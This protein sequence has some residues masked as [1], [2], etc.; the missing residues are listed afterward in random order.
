MGMMERKAAATF[1]TETLP[2]LK[3]QIQEAC[4]FELNIEVNLDELASQ[5]K[6]DEFNEGW[7]KIYFQPLNKAMQEICAD[8]FGK[9]A[10]KEG[11]KKVVIRNGQDNYS[12]H[13]WA[14]IEDGVLTL[15]HQSD[16]NHDDIDARAKCV[17][18][19]LSEAL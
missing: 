17:V 9:G 1:E 4:G 19:K 15:N 10:V 7:D 11:L 5:G 13:R 3:K 18:E 12:A 16:T 14:S 2:A 6:A 8:D